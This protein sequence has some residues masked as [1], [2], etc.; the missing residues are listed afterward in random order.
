MGR[1]FLRIWAQ[2]PTTVISGGSFAVV[3]LVPIGVRQAIESVC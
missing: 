3:G 2:Q 1:Q